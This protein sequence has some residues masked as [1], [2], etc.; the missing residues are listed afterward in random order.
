MVGCAIV[1]GDRIIGE[2]FHKQFGGPHAEVNAINSATE[3]VEGADVYINLEPC[4]YFGKTPPC[5]D[6]LIARQVRKVYVAMLDPNPR[7]NGKGLKQLTDAGIEVEIGLASEEARQLNEAFA[8][9]ELKG[10]PFVAMKVAQ[11][12]DGKIALRNG[13]SKYLTSKESLMSVHRLRA[14]YDAVLVGAGTVRADD[15]ELTVRLVEGRS[16]VRIIL[17]GNLS[18]PV[19][20]RVFNDGKARTVVFC[21]SS[22]EDDPR[23]GKKKIDV[24]RR[25]KVEVYPIRGDSGGMISINVILKRIA[26]MGISSIMVE[27]GASVFSQFVKSGAADKLYLYIAPKILGRGIGF[28]DGIEL[29]DLRRT[30]TLKKAEVTQVGIDYLLKAYF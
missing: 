15:P 17:D 12:I 16:P 28:A 11:S 24:L 23:V 7:V 27:G 18:S 4:N 26:K 3:D 1:K 13:R 5:T 14:E 10:L 20:S 21:A 2:G 29:K 25:R 30:P 8:K 9:F 6:L 19:S 22:L